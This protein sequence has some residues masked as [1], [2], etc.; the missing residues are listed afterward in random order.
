M[1]DYPALPCNRGW[2]RSSY[3][4]NMTMISL[5]RLSTNV[6]LFGE[7]IR[8]A[9]ATRAKDPMPGLFGWTMTAAMDA[10]IFAYPIAI[11]A[12]E[13]AR[14]WQSS[15]LGLGV[16]G[17]VGLFPLRCLLTLGVIAVWVYRFMQWFRYIGWPQAWGLAYVLLILFPWTWVFAIEF[18]SVS[19][20]FCCSCCRHQLS[21][22]THPAYTLV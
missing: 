2:G 13:I 15:D 8:V 6:K 21:P 14:R 7:R 10:F 3:L 9:F 1:A 17:I 5:K 18:R 20:R 4:S 11:L 22:Y 16:I 19:I 12:I